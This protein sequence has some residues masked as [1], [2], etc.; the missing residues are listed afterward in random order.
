VVAAGLGDID[1]ARD[2]AAVARAKATQRAASSVM[3]WAP[4]AEGEVRLA[5]GEPAAESFA[6]A[7]TQMRRHGTPLRRVE[8]LTGL[9]LA[10]DEPEIAAAAVAAAIAVRDEQHMVLPPGIAARLDEVWER[11]ASIVGTDRWAQKVSDLSARPHDELLDLL[12]RGVAA[13]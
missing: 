1:R 3:G 5:A 10:V 9:A 8:V 11:W 7:L 4:W 2:L 12:A 6:S 13:G